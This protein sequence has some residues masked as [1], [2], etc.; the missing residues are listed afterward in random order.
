[1]DRR[2]G[3]LASETRVRSGP[4]RSVVASLRPDHRAAYPFAA[5][6][7]EPGRPQAVKA[8]AVA[9]PLRGFGLDGL[10]PPRFGLSKQTKAGWGRT[11]LPTRTAMLAPMMCLAMAATTPEP[12]TARLW[13]PRADRLRERMMTSEIAAGMRAYMQETNRLNRQSEAHR[14]PPAAGLPKLLKPSRRSC[15]S[16]SKAVGTIR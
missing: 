16:S 13:K 6:S 9:P 11:A 2:S 15:A 10:T 8:D 14:N 12:C 1:M 5:D 3:I 7:S 4:V